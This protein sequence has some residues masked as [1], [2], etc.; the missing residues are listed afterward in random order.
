MQSHIKNFESL[1][2]TPLRRTV[3]EILEKGIESIRTENVILGGVRLDGDILSIQEKTFDL[4]LYKR[5]IVVGFGKASAE[6]ALALEKVLGQ[7]I[8]TGAVI[9]L[10]EQEADIIQ[11]LAG[12]HPRPS[13]GNVVAGEKIYEL[14]DG[15][16]EDDLIIALVS[17][18][19]SALLCYGN[20]ECEQGAK[21]YDAFLGAGKTISE[22]NTVRKHLSVLKGGGL[23]RLAYPAT[24]VGLIFSDVPGDNFGDVASGPTYKD[25][26]TVADALR[27]IRENNLGE[28]ELTE[29][30][31]EDKY[32]EKVHNFVLVSNTT[33]LS[34]MEKAGEEMGLSTRV[35]S[36]ELYDKG[37]EAIQKI[38]S[39]KNDNTLVLAAGEPKIEVSGGGG[40]GG[41][42]THLSLEVLG[43][44]ILREDS[45]FVSLASDGLDNSDMAGAVAD[46]ETLRKAEEVGLTLEEYLKD[47][48]SYEYFKKTGDLIETGATGANVSDLMI[49]FTK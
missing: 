36:A 35:V 16:N 22:M 13:Q 3:L 20:K 2:V 23:A 15:A 12:T 11:I 26:T 37:E 19:G 32:F 41:R 43:K 48:N 28:F 4:S 6:A 40:K 31:K 25:E 8:S 29:T 9:G 27:I 38:F 17:G 33:A 10:K 1:A 18:G 46:S 49:L 34:A 21:L 47:F 45:V 14:I 30:P 5:I 24:V 7:R 44:N 42:N 39:Q